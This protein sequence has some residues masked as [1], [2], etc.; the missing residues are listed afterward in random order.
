VALSA[1]PRIKRI[2]QEENE[3]REAKRKT[4]PGAPSK[5]QVEEDKRRAEEEA[6]VKEEAD[7]V[8]LLRRSHVLAL[9]M[10]YVGCESRG[11]EGEGCCCQR[12]EEGTPRCE[13]RDSWS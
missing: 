8:R 9:L 11:K 2:K 1:D 10:G 12:C 6:K 5:A 13:I 4:K 7:K 3:P